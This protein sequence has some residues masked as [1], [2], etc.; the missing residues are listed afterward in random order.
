MSLQTII[1]NKEK[2][3]NHFTW[4]GIEIFIKDKF[5][6]KDISLKS[7][8]ESLEAK[9]PKHLLRNVEAIYIGDFDFLNDRDVQASYQDSAIYV[10]NSQDDEEDMCD[11]I[12][13]EIAHSVEE[14]YKRYIYAD[15]QL[16]REFLTKRKALFNILSAEG[17]HYSPAAFLNPEYDKG[18]DEFLYKT[19]GYP[20]LNMVTADIYYSPY[21]ATSL[22]EYFANGFEALFYFGEFEFISK[23]CPKLFEKLNGLLEIKN[24]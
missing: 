19:A 16:E 7:A 21:A 2:E 5:T 1:K 8:L 6:N 22:R 13:H 23:S 9:V 14:M 3:K 17:I 15:G 24:D 20:L 18:F 12:V 11:D 10:T 4:N